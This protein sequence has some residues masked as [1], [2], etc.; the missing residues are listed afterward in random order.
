MTKKKKKKHKLR[1]LSAPNNKQKETLLRESSFQYS[2]PL[3]PAQQY[4]QYE[5]VC[6]GS[7]DRIL[8]MAEKQS[9]HRHG[10]EKSVIDTNNKLA[11]WGL[12][13]GGFIVLVCIGAGLYLTMND[14]WLS[15]GLLTFSGIA[16]VATVF[17]TNR[18]D[19]KEK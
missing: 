9:S 15:G 3:P 16:T 11:L 19:K 17:V 18:L 6:P 8:Q 4:A 2:G 13:V 10:I 12:F 1:E 14:R 7:A 5:Q